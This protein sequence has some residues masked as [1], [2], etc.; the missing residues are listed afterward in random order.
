MAEECRAIVLAYGKEYLEN[1]VH[2]Q[3]RV[4]LRATAAAAACT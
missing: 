4:P 3:P 1:I 2:A